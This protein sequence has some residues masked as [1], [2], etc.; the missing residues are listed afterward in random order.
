MPA[1]TAPRDSSECAHAPLCVSSG[2]QQAFALAWLAFH[3]EVACSHA[4]DEQVTM[5]A[6][7]RMDV[8]PRFCVEYMVGGLVQFDSPRPLGLP[9]AIICVI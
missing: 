7:L 4:N 6:V 9:I 5:R 2:S 1:A 3:S 8:E